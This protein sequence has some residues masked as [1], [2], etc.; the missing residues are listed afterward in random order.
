[1]HVRCRL[2]TVVRTD[3]SSEFLSCL[4]LSFSL[5]DYQIFLQSSSRLSLYHCQELVY[6]LQRPAVVCGFHILP[7]S[8]DDDHVADIWY[9]HAFRPIFHTSDQR[10]PPWGDMSGSIPRI[11]RLCLNVQH[12]CIGT[13]LWLCAEKEGEPLGDA[14][15]CLEKLASLSRSSSGIYGGCQSCPAGFSDMCHRRIVPLELKKKHCTHTAVIC[16]LK[17]AQER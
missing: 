2:W 11:H 10:H 1:M 15:G 8:L 6:C 16:R 17:D 9:R 12:I 3:C 5:S 13:V 7:V 14:G 4:S